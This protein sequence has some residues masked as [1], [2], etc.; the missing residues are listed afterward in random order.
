MPHARGPPSVTCIGRYKMRTRPLT[1]RCFFSVSY[2]GPRPQAVTIEG[3]GLSTFSLHPVKWRSLFHSG[4][5]LR[6]DEGVFCRLTSRSGR[7]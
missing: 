4:L 2:L 1:W 6:F 5:H 7:V 3:F